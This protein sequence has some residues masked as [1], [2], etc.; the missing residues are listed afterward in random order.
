VKATTKDHSVSTV[1]GKIMLN[2]ETRN[3]IKLLMKALDDLSI[4]MNYGYRPS[5]ATKMV[6]ER[7]EKALEKAHLLMEK[8]SVFIAR[9][10]TRCGIL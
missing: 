1:K 7:G 8:Q 10:A 2:S 5:T 9:N 3:V 4:D 6:L